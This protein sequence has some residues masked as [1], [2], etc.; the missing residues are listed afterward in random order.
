MQAAKPKTRVVFPKFGEPCVLGLAIRR[1]ERNSQKHMA[2]CYNRQLMVRRLH[3]WQG[4]LGNVALLPPVF[5]RD[6]TIPILLPVGFIGELWLND[7]LNT[8]VTAGSLG[9]GKAC[10]SITRLAC[11]HM[12]VSAKKTLVDWTDEEHVVYPA[13]MPAP[14]DDTA[15]EPADKTVNDLADEDDNANDANDDANNKLADDDNKSEHDDDDE[16]SDK[17]ATPK[18]EEDESEDESDDE[19]KS[20]KDRS[21]VLRDSG[22]GGSSAS[23]GVGA[24]ASMSSLVVHPHIKHDTSL[25]LP[26]RLPSVEALEELAN[27]LYAYSGELFC[28]LEETSMAMLDRILSGF[29]KSGRRAHDYIHETAAIALNFFSRAGEMEA[30]LE[31]SEVP[32]FR[33]AINGMKDSIR[34]LIRWTSM[35]EESYEEAA[36]QFDNILASVSDELKEFVEAWGEGQRQEYIAKCMN[37]IRGIHGSLDGTQFIPMMVTNATTHH[38]LSLSARVNQLQ[39]PLQIM[40]SPMRTQ[41]ATMGARLKFVEFLSRRVLALDVKLGPTNAVSLESGGEGSGVVSAPGGGTTPAAPSTPASKKP[42]SPKTPVTAHTSTKADH[43]Y[44]APKAKTPETPSKPKTLEMPSKPKTPETPSKPKT[45]LS[46]T[47]SATLT[48]FKGMSDDDEAPWK[49]RAKSTSQEVPARK[50]KVEVESDSYSSPTPTK[51]ETPK[52]VKKKTKKKAPSSGK[53]SSS[54]E[55]ERLS[56]KKPPKDKADIITWANQDHTSKWKKDLG[57]VVRY[58]Q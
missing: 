11:C 38:A 37:R 56:S 33:N 30:E 17:N 3:R 32:K 6:P 19:S 15:N 23:H 18:K 27:D 21:A 47:A 58:R 43:T 48:K 45:M 14:K 24:G 53:S 39:I 20:P 46:P 34:D 51:S 55:D 35:V 49:R 25:P 12:E 44:G 9:T 29:K 28:G 54:S 7:F 22:L 1:Q 42:N 8:P 2:M 26:T 52:K 40:I 13:A 16:E 10:P 5:S 57:H 31:S 36:A 4:R 41:A 50:A